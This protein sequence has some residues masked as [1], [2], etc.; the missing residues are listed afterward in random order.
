MGL[1]SFFKL[2][3]LSLSLFTLLFFTFPASAANKK[4]A[5]LAGKVYDEDQTH[6]LKG[7]V[8]RIV[9]LETG[10]A[11]QEKTNDEGCYNF[12]KIP[13]GSYSVSVSYNG[14]DY[15]LAEKVKVEKIEEKDV[16]VAVCVALGGQNALVQL[17][18]CQLCRKGFPV[19]FILI[20]AGG[21]GALSAII[22]TSEPPA[23]PSTP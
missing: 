11:L 4:D 16:V 21:V 9:N 13:E 5:Y 1:G 18:N 19:L 10:Q 7:V 12:K 22:L 2:F 23:S 6:P 15:L 17:Q 8:V 3:A 20:P 14:Q